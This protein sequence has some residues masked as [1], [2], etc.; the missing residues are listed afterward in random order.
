LAAVALIS[1]G[2]LSVIHKWL[3]LWDLSLRVKRPKLNL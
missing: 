3:D 2:L 1:S